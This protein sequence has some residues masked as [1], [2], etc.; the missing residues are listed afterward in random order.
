[1]DTL[2]SPASEALTSIPTQE[3]MGH[4]CLPQCETEVRTVSPC[5]ASLSIKVTECMKPVHLAR[6]PQSERFHPFFNDLLHLLMVLSF[7]FFFV[8]VVVGN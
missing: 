8:V 6:A 4:P 3:I 2:E 1:M 7:S 5:C